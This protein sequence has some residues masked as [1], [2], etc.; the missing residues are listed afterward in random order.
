MRNPLRT[1][2]KS[3]ILLLATVMIAGANTAA[4]RT[5]PL[6]EPDAIQTGVETYILRVPAS[7]DGDDSPCHDE[8]RNARW[9][10]RADGGICVYA[11]ISHCSIPRGDRTE[12]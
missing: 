6:S 10:T 2:H 9:D 4:S 12:R 8:R 3:T 1:I 11:G 7:H 5:K